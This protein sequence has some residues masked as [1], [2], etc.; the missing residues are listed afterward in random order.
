M[1]RKPRNAWKRQRTKVDSVATPFLW[2]RARFPL[3]LAERARSSTAQLRL[4]ETPVQQL[5]T[6]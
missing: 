2:S 1:K 5:E 6:S 4:T 3:R